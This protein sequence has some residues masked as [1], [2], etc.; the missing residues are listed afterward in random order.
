MCRWGPSPDQQPTPQPPIS[1]HGASVS[2]VVN[3]KPC[4]GQG[5]GWQR[6]QRQGCLS[7][8][9]RA[10]RE[11]RFQNLHSWCHRQQNSHRDQAQV[12]CQSS[13]PAA[14][15]ETTHRAVD[16]HHMASTAR[17][18]PK[19]SGSGLG[20]GNQVGF[21]EEQAEDRFPSLKEGRVTRHMPS[22]STGGRVWAVI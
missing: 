9:L 6:G 17:E 8:T 3:R 22:G 16:G 14:Q 21:L 20:Q 4:T 5:R 10:L 7:R 2:R 11:R 13:G 1:V 18:R 19:G 12:C 15:A